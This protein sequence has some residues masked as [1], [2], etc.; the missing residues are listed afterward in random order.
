M[1]ADRDLED[2][3]GRSR[4]SR[5]PSSP[6]TTT[7]GSASCSSR[8]APLRARHTDALLIALA[9]GLLVAIIL[10]GVALAGGF[11]A[12]ARHLRPAARHLLAAERARPDVR[13]L[14]RG[15]VL[16]RRA[17][18]HRRRLRRQEGLLLQDRPRRTAA[19]RGPRAQSAYELEPPRHAGATRFP[20]T[21]RTA[22][23]RSACSGS[24]GRRRGGG[25]GSAGGP[26]GEQTAD[27]HGT[28][29]TTEEAFDGAITITR[30]WLDGRKTINSAADDPS[31]SR[32]D[33]AERPTTW[34]E[35]TF[36][37]RD[38]GLERHGHTSSPSA[39]PDWL[40]ERMSAAA[41]AAGDPDAIA[42]WT[43]HVPSLCGAIRG[44]RG[45]CERRG[46]VE[47]RVDR[48]PPRRLHDAGP[49]RHRTSAAPGR[50][51]VALPPARQGHA[52]GHL[53]GRER[54]AFD[55]SMF[56]LQGRTQLPAADPSPGGGVNAC[57]RP[58]CGKA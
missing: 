49:R 9:V 27:V 21:S 43:H 8:S 51:R 58:R 10:G 30:Q 38:D 3:A 19:T 13:Q 1:S 12:A 22:R 44:R 41:R 40:A 50:L 7:P 33:K 15:D 23:P 14:R 16:R 39:A 36:W 18:P 6:R 26:R 45:A 24:A 20:S 57:D 29:I 4:A 25:W 34:R 47:R 55:T 54:R 42:R 11:D 48:H 17:G 5:S 31:L 46:E 35:I 53:Q 2:G 28:V 52:R 32:L 56:H 37:F